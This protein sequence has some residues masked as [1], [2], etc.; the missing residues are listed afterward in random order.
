MAE[1]IGMFSKLTLTKLG[2][3]GDR[4]SEKGGGVWEKT[5]D[6]GGGAGVGFFHSDGWSRSLHAPSLLY[7]FWC[8]VW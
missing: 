4:E 7:T 2:S 1:P 8:P 3:L 5:D 6:R